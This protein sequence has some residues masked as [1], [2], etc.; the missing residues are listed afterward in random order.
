MQAYGDVVA[1]LGLSG[2][3]AIAA[4]P[5]RLMASIEKGLPVA[6]LDRVARLLAPEDGQ[7]KY[8]LVPKATYERRKSAHR[9]STDEGT[10][11]ARVARVWSLA[12]DVWKSEEEARDF[13]FRPHAMLEDMRP[14]DAV[15][16]GEIG[17]ELVMDILGRLKYGIAA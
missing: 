16:R 15:M 3:V 11:L 8:R 6:A 7:F 1:V 10:R 4:S 14:I 13:L 5:F 2:D 9:L 12:V 17:A